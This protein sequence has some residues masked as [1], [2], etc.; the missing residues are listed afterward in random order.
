M[1]YLESPAYQRER[2]LMKQSELGATPYA[3]FDFT[4][5]VSLDDGTMVGFVFGTPRVTALPR[6]WLQS[7]PPESDGTA[8]FLN[9]GCRRGGRAVCTGR[10]SAL[11]G[12]WR[13]VF[14]IY[15]SIKAPDIRCS[16]FLH[17]FR[18]TA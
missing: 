16:Y 18:K 17:I 2:G 8:V 13:N 7:L 14:R 9:A 4:N 5:Y 11:D 12:E 10:K 15:L 3:G 1:A 6:T